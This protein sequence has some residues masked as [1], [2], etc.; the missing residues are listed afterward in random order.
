ME[1]HGGKRSV[2]S[3]RFLSKFDIAIY[4]KIGPS[5]GRDTN[6]CFDRF[7]RLYLRRIF[8][9]FWISVDVYCGFNVLGALGK[10]AQME[11]DG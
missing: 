8:L 5:Y 2:A 3:F 9:F 4:S 11:E 7:L 10:G 6:K 1:L